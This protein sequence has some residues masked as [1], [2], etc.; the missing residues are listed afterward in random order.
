MQLLTP[1]EVATRLK[2][3]PRTVYSW[4]AEGRLEAVHLSERVT[5]V[6]EEAVRALV[7]TAMTPAPAAGIGAGLVAEEPASYGSTATLPK[8]A[9]REP[10]SESERLRALL[11][12][13]R[14]DIVTVVERSKGTNVRV[15]GSVVHGDATENSDLDLLVDAQPGMSLFDLSEIESRLEE[16]LGRKVDVAVARSLR[17]E[18]KERV[19]AEARAL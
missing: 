10:E 8:P 13:H 15:F 19:L 3:S 17:V 14:N 2:V 16:L 11:R 12:E 5:R 6:P 4:I 9:E 1:K 7:A 18:V